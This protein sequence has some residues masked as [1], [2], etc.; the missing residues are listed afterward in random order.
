MIGL[1]S[2]VS[3][4][5]SFTGSGNF[6]IEF[7][8][9]P[10]NLEITNNWV[11][12]T[13]GKSNQSSLFPVSASGAGLVF[14]GNNVFQAFDGE[15]HV[16]QGSGV[17]SGV[18]L[19]IVM[20]AS[21]EAFDNDPVQYSAFANGE[22]MIVNISPNLG[23][24][25][26]DAGGYDNNY[27]SLYSFNDPG[28]TNN[29]SL[30]DNLKISKVENI[31]TVTNW[32]SDSDMLPMNPAKTT[33]AVN[34]NGDSVTINGVDF[35]GTGVAT[36]PAF[37][38][39]GSA[40]LQSNGWELMSANGAVAFHNSEQ[41]TNLVTDSGTKTLM[42]YFAYFNAPGGAGAI[43]LSDLTPNSSNVISIY[44]YGWGNPGAGRF[45]YFSS[46]AGGSITNIDQ[47]TYGLGSGIIVRYSYMADKNGEC[48]I[49]LSPVLNAG[50]HLSGFYSEEIAAVP[51]EISAPDKLDFGEILVGMPATLQLEVMNIGE[52][53]VSGSISGISAPFSMADSYY[54][55]SATSD[56]MIVTFT[57][58]GEEDY[59]ETIT[60]SGSG[61][62]AQ[63]ELTGTGVPEAG[64]AFGILS[65]FAFAFRRINC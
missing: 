41:V 39:N 45:V 64:I 44:S 32:L 48:T 61:G 12:L 38:A 40:I 3:P 24:I 33:H 47:D 42:E 36:N 50:W 37:H 54:S 29:T 4:N 20:T 56:I 6:K 55:T 18:P 14:F 16:G 22:P 49:V 53:V 9:V 8:V 13:F 65:F 62:D 59:M 58:S 19:H 43:K 30:F 34:I 15:T 28:I 35:I 10:H 31:V 27:I 57:P 5:Y 17:P 2:G 26:N 52:G 51:A 46:S 23:Y 11:G 63:V 25:Y 7:D 60:L 1:S 21:T